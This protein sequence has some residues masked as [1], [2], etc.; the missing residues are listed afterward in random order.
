MPEITKNLGKLRA[1]YGPSPALLQRAAIVAVVS[2]IFFLAMLVA[3]SM[4]Q[5]IGYFVLST[6][7]LIVQMLTLFGWIAQRKNE[8]KIYDDGFV[9]RK[10]TCLWSEIARI[11]SKNV[12]GAKTGGEIIKK[13]GDKIMLTEALHNVAEILDRI[14][15]KVAP[16][17]KLTAGEK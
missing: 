13:T 9:Y 14:S 7:F 16:E 3:F 4:R 10:K 11:N 8:L 15:K 2:F 1:V 17:N 6:A 12:N 5:N